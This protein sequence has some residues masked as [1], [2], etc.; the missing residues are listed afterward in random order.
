[1]FLFS[2]LA[3]LFFLSLARLPPPNIALRSGEGLTVSL[4]A[5]A[6]PS[7]PAASSPVPSALLSAA[8]EPEVTPPPARRILNT[9]R[10]LAPPRPARPP[11]PAPDPVEEAIAAPAGASPDA[12]G[13]GEVSSDAAD[14]GGVSQALSGGAGQGGDAQG[15]E[16]MT[17]ALAAY[18]IAIGDNARKLRRYP[19]RARILGHEGRVEIRLIWRPGMGVPQVDLQQ[20]SGSALL[21]RQGLDM[22][23][24]AAAHTPLP[25]VLRQRA[26]SLMLPVEFSLEE[27]R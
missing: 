24:Q 18:L 9:P 16:G 11:E 13:A 20:G 17:E 21:D 4:R 10:R 12:S 15:V 19:D 6:L 23:R 26:F 14:A 1:M 25:E 2:V 8:V 5:E 22:L 27:A 7:A 3:H